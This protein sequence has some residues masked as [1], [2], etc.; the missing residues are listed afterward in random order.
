[1]ADWSDQAGSLDAVVG[2]LLSAHG[3][4]VRLLQARVGPTSSGPKAAAPAK[5]DQSADD[6]ST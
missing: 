3:H 6:D 2:A 1:M 5:D 4:D